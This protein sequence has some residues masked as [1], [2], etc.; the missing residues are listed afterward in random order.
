MKSIE[1]TNSYMN[2]ELEIAQ[3]QLKEFKKFPSENPNPIL[4]FDSDS[5]LVYNNSASEDHFIYDF[6]LEEKIVVDP[7]LQRILSQ[8]KEVNN[9]HSHIEKKNG[10]TYSIKS[11]Y[12]R[13]IDVVNIY[14]SDISEFVRRVDEN[15]ESLI[16]LKNEIQKQKEFYEFILNNLPADI[17]VFDKNHKYVYVNPRGI[18]NKKVR[19]FII[20][21]DDF[22]YAKFKNIPEDFAIQRRRIFNSIMRKKTFVNWSDYNIDSEGKR[23]VIQ[24]SMGPLFDEKGNVKYVIGYGTDITKRVLTEEE[25]QM[26]SSVAKST[27]NGVL[28]VNMNRVITWANEALLERTGFRLKDILGKPS[29]Y[30][31]MLG[32]SDNAL[33][34]LKKA[35][36]KNENKSVE[37]FYESRTKK[38]YWV[39]LSVQPL[40][41]Q[42]GNQT[43][44]MFVEFDITSRIK[45]EQ[46]IQNLNANLENLVRDKTAKNIALSNSLRDQEKMVTIGELAAGVA[47]DLN[48]PLAAIKSG[49]EN[50]KYILMNLFKKNFGHC[51]PNEVEFAL[52]RIAFQEPQLYIGG[53]SMKNESKNFEL[54]LEE[55]Y[56]DYNKE[57]R[58]KLAFLFAKNRISLSEKDDILYIMN[59]KNPIQFLELY[60]N[61][62]VTLSFLNT[63][64]NSGD[65]ASNV[66]HDL[67]SFIKEKKNTKKGLVNIHSNIKTVLNIFNYNLSSSIELKFDV[68][69]DIEVMGYDVRL[70]QLWSNLIKNAIECMDD[71]QTEKKLNIIS[72]SNKKTFS[73]TFENNGPMIPAEMSEKIFDKFFTTKGAANGS[74]L[75]LSI[76]KNVVQEHHAKIILISNEKSTQ[77]KI[78]FNR[79]K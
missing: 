64:S 34:E 63:I 75:G 66:V 73:V 9:S 28:V 8:A 51:T 21:K 18:K 43:G 35:M 11:K 13:E 53:L 42:S 50:I 52:N 68:D 58:S 56:S 1:K 15:E 67:R 62:S 23:E 45:N 19:D 59:A 46:T 78:T 72:R 49:A 32:S 54:F 65:K 7:C 44:F 4:R 37:L 48:T 40:F 24:R 22:D 70:F 71:S 33:D 60:N 3:K 30:F 6:N 55:N 38:E 2:K 20:G 16:Q 39:D 27:N 41:D 10:R 36:D 77:F 57:D 25:N 29:T 12:V 69:K 47:H 74:G 76:V 26:L 31:R 14:A 17:A 61:L 5:R 79:A